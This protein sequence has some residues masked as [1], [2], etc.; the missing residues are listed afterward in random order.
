MTPPASR[1]SVTFIL[2]TVALDVLSLG[3]V[4]PVLPFLVQEFVGGDPARAAT[5]FGLMSVSWAL[6]QL[7][8]SPIFAGLSDTYGRRPILLASNFGLGLDYILMALAP[9]IAWLFAGRVLSGI[10]AATFSTATAYIADVTPQEKRA[11]A[12][13]MIGA[14]FGIGFVLGPALGGLL[15]AYDPRLPFVVAALLSLINAVYGTFVLPESLAK[16]NRAPFRLK[17]ANPVGA[18]QLLFGTASLRP[19]SLVLFLYHLAHAVLPAVFVLFASY[20]FNWGAKE[21]GSALALVGICGAIV[22]AGLTRFAVARFGAHRTL[23]IGLVAGTAGFLIQ[24]ITTSPLVYLCGVPLFSLWGFITPAAMQI[25]SGRVGLNEQ[26]RLQGANSSIM[27]IAS[28]IGPLV[29]TS[30]FA[31]AVAPGP[32]QAL[33]GAPFLLA[34][35]LLAVATVLAVRATRH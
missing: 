32:G 24:G 22:Q 31:W 8:F 34:A 25:L 26:G 30:I 9:G 17:T 18:L 23:L 33:A 27:S 16:E 7:I 14:S 6:M 21:V 29:F 28:L 20:R 11:A 5:I 12:F 13:G 2:V 35:A 19:L 4:I 3:L 10:F 1:A 15:G